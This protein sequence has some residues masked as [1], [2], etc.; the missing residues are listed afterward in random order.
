MVLNHGTS[1]RSIHE[2]S[3][4]NTAVPSRECFDLMYSASKNQ[5]IWGCNYFGSNI[6]DVG[7]IVHD[8]ELLIEDTKLKWSEADLASCSMQ[9]RITIFRYRWNGNVQG[10]AINWNNTGKDARV[11]PTQKPLALMRHCINKY[12]K[13]QHVIL[14]PYMG[15]GTT[16]VAAKELNRRAIGIEIHEPYCEIAAKRLSQEVFDFSEIGA[17]GNEG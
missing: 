9:K 8:K 3:D 7:R 6:R 5:I 12:S 14:D 13:E 10:N 16:L 1:E 4:W 11:H 17:L 2:C 15:S